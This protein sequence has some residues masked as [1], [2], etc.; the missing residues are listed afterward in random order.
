MAPI[1]IMDIFPALGQWVQ[2]NRDAL[3]APYA[4]RAQEQAQTLL[5]APAANA[6]QMDE[7]GLVS[8]V[9]TPGSGLMQDPNDYMNQMQ[10]ALGLMGTPGYES[11]GLQ[12]QNQA[13]ANQ[14][15][16]PAREQAQ[17]NFEAQQMQRAQLAAQQAGVQAAQFQ[18]NQ[19][20]QMTQ[21]ALSQSRGMARDANAILQ[22]IREGVKL[23]SNVNDVVRDKGFS[24]MNLTDDTVMTKT[25]A[26]LVLP[27]EAVM[28]GDIAALQTMEG[29]TPAIRAAASK[30]GMGVPLQAQERTQLYDQIQRLGRQ[31]LGELNQ[32]RQDFEQRAVRANFDPR[33]VLRTAPTVNTGDY[34]QAPPPQV[35]PEIE[36][37]LN[38]KAAEEDPSWLPSITAPQ[39][40]QDMMQ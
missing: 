33:D 18:Q 28:E 38:A 15:G 31:Q 11:A 20:R 39:W 14:L 23:Y 2:G 35:T 9:S 32:T 26:K 40:Y 34:R 7:S 12:F 6:M 27:N 29:L 16:N 13:V 3:M 1:G 19:Q 8:G 25:L 5:G 17:R 10:Y 21:D 4:E 37:R 24:G 22:P 36:Q 30:I